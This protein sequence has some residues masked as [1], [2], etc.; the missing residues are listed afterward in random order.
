MG[1]LWPRGDRSVSYRRRGRRR[2]TVDN[3]EVRLDNNAF[4]FRTGEL[5]NDSNI[6]LPSRLPRDLQ[7]G[8][9]Q[10]VDRSRQAPNTIELTPMWNILR[11]L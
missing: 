6:P 8:R 3:G 4:D 9:P 11:I 7:E 1:S 2:L 5:K 10:D